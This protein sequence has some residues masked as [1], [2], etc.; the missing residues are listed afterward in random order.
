VPVK[1]EGRLV[2]STDGSLPLPQQKRAKK[3]DTK[4][5]PG[6]PPDDGVVRVGCERRRGGSVTQIHGVP[7]RDVA[8]IASELRRALGTGGTVKNGVVE[9]QGDRRDAVIAY[10]DANRRAQ[11]TKKM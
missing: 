2:Y 8:T 5:K 9:L 10:F 6:V 3:P 1:D 4:S 11:R 7:S